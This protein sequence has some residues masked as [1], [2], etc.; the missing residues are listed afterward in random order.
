M[1]QV[2]WNKNETESVLEKFELDHIPDQFL[3]N[4][5]TSKLLPW[6]GLKITK[7]IYQGK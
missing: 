6:A 4:I 5:R 7:I 2:K 3:E 1:L